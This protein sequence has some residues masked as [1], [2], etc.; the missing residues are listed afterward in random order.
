M[1][2]RA[3]KTSSAVTAYPMPS[4]KPRVLPGG[5]SRSLQRAIERAGAV[6][7]ID[8]D[9]IAANW[10]FLADRLSPGARCASVVKADAYGLGVAEV[11][12]ALAR[13]GCKSF[14]V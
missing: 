2:P 8:L 13:A 7:D 11:A 9:A 10:K 6:L 12:P 1:T 4:R 14:F 3:S 5:Q